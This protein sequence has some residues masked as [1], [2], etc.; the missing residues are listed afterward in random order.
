MFFDACIF[1]LFR[2]NAKG[3]LGNGERCVEADKQAVKLVFCRLGTVDGPWQY[4]PVSLSL[5]SSVT[6]FYELME[7]CFFFFLEN[8]H[9]AAYLPTQVLRRS[10]ANSNARF[11]A[12]RPDQSL[13]AV[14]FQRNRTEME[15]NG[16]DGTAV[17]TIR[18]HSFSILR[19]I[20]NENATNTL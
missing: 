16:A 20:V 15:I 3:Q 9:P 1:Q 7:M 5:S 17:K 14:D 2:L 8:N 18:R 4:D 12:L 10:S 6:L 19:S 13:S 11:T